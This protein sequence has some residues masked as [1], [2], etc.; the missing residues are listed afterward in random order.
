M[1]MSRN[2]F[3]LCALLTISGLFT[4]RMVIWAQ[5]YPMSNTAFDEASGNVPS[6][7]ESIVLFKTVGTDVNLCANTDE[8]TLPYGGGEV[9]YC[10]TIQNTGN[11]T[12]SEHTL[13]DNELGTLLD[14]VYYEVAPGDYA[15][16]TATTTITE[17]TVNTATWTAELPSDPDTISASDTDTAVVNVSPATPT[18]S[19]SP[20]SLAANQPGNVQTTQSFTITN[21]GTGD[22]S[23]FIEELNGFTPESGFLLYDNGPLVNSPGTGAGGADESMLQNV[24]LN[25]STTGFAHQVLNSNRVADDFTVTGFGWLVE[26]VVFFAYQ[27]NS[28]ITSTITAVNLRIWDGPPGNTGSNIIFGDAFTN[29]LLATT[30]SGIYRV[31]E[32]TSGNTQRPIMANT[33]EVGLFLPPGTYW[34]DWQSDGTLASGPWVPPITINGQN[35]TGNGLQGL[36]G[37]WVPAND[38]TT[39]TQQGFPF[40]LYGIP[41]CDTDIPWASANPISGTTPVGNTSVVDVT[42][43]STGL[44]PGSYNGLLCI[45]NND[46]VSP[47]VPITLTLEVQ[48]SY[49]V[50]VGPDDATSDLPGNTVTYTLSV[51]NSGNVTDTFDLTATGQAWTTTLSANDI[52]LSPGESAD[53]SVWVDIPANAGGDS[54]TTTVT[55]TSQGDNSA[56]DSADLTTTAVETAV[57]GVTLSGDDALTGLAGTTVTYTLYLTNTGNVADTFDITASGE[58][59]TTTLSANNI[60]L[61]ANQSGWVEVEVQ[62]PAGAANGDSDTVTITATSQGDNSVTASADLTTTASVIITPSNFIYLPVILKP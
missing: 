45:Y 61:N 27:T 35:T 48:T 4:A 14:N 31:S 6:G 9:T 53:I 1:N 10:Y 15:Y 49:G 26:E 12:L 2:F 37:V 7:G 38:G 28:P 34:L 30:W 3:V 36:A 19:V 8:I 16:I 32:T 21:S 23:W 29:R 39:L 46:P 60:T 13:V 11:I 59:W 40:V 41:S 22:L 51:T 43:D 18:I 47:L 17:T 50:Q 44:P 56:S 24:T 25:M 20:T 54:D 42:F 57:Y 33:V 5:P 58:T 62:I 55:A 52:T